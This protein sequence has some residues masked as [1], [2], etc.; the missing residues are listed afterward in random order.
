MKYLLKVCL[1]IAAI[2]ASDYKRNNLRNHYQDY[3]RYLQE[4]KTLQ[5]TPSAITLQPTP[6]SITL[7]PTPTSFD[8]DTLQP[9]PSA[10]TLQPTPSA[11][12]LQPT[13]NNFP[14]SPDEPTN[15]TPTNVQWNST[16]TYYLVGAL[17]AVLLLLLLALFLQS[18]SRESPSNDSG[19][20]LQFHTLVSIL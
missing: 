6:S 10:I 12:T 7:Q 14:T 20:Y 1:F 3:Q 4:K 9:T 16:D 11:F 5:P 13:P 8:E 18:L 17:G 15:E 2:E 19:P